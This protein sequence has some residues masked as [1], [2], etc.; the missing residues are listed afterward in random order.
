MQN[1]VRRSL[2]WLVA[3]A[4]MIAGLPVA[5]VMP[6]QAATAQHADVM[7]AAAAP[8]HHCDEMAMAAAP[9]A[10]EADQATI[11]QA[12]I[13]QAN[14]DH[15]NAGA[16]CNCL[17]CSMCIANFVTPP[18]RF[19]ALERRMV[20][21]TYRIDAGHLAGTVPPIDPGIPILAS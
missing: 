19:A 1:L 20:A 18:Q 10:D 5:H 9:V 11:D 16:P 7:A 15:A 21:V 12:A 6:V 2:V 14:T 3:V 17:N 8:A 13:D 4:I